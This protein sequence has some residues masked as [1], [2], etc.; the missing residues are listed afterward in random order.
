MHPVLFGS[1]FLF[2]LLRFLVGR[3]KDGFLV[4][5]DNE[6]FEGAGVLGCLLELA[7][8]RKEAFVGT[9]SSILGPVD[10]RGL[11]HGLQKVADAL[12]P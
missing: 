12:H 9:D 2:F 4:E 6:A 7:L 11:S 8:G 10:E 3:G 5:L 1:L